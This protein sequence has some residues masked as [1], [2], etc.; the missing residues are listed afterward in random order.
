MKLVYE[1]CGLSSIWSNVIRFLRLTLPGKLV[2]F[3]VDLSVEILA[4]TKRQTSAGASTHI[5]I[6]PSQIHVSRKCKEFRQHKW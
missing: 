2:A 6:D 4:I 3:V 1:L 5:T